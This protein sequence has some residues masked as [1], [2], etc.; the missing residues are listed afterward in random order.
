MQCLDPNLRFLFVVKF[1]EQKPVWFIFKGIYRT[2]N[3]SF[4]LLGGIVRIYSIFVEHMLGY[5]RLESLYY[6]SNKFSNAFRILHGN[7]FIG[8]IPKEIGLLKDL[9]VLDLGANQLSGPIPP[10]IGNLNSIIKM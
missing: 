1:C 10:E 3:L 5:M 2:R 4:I 7:K 6:I 8:T 9:R